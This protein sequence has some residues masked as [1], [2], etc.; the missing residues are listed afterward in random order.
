MM[1]NSPTD[2]ARMAVKEGADAIG[3]N[4]GVGPE[5]TSRWPASFAPPARCDLDQGQRGLPTVGKDGRHNL[6]D[7]PRRFAAFVPKWSRPAANFVGGCCGTTPGHIEAV[8]K[9]VDRI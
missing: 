8:R 6:P 3:A 7:G 2:L 4:C 9:A 5:T 1:G